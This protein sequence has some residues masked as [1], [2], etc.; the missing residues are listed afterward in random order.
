MA[1]KS[2]IAAGFGQAFCTREG[3][4]RDSACT[5][6]DEPT[7]RGDTAEGASRVTDIRDELQALDAS[8]A[9]AKRARKGSRAFS[10]AYDAESAHR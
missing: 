6:A 2:T 4:A 5:E 8:S 7:S 1:I 3:Q 10:W 9:C